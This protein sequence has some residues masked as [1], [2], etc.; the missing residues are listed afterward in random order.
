MLRSAGGAGLNPAVPLTQNFIDN[1]TSPGPQTMN[2][3]SGKICIGAGQSQV[4]INN[5]LVTPSSRINVQLETIDATLKSLVVQPFSA[6]FQVNGN[7][8]ATGQVT[9]NF[10]IIN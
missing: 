7:A 10:S 9:I 2:V 6:V 3:P 5:N 1:G 8:N 4:Q